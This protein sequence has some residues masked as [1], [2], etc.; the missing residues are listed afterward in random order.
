MRARTL[1]TFFGCVYNC[2]YCVCYDK[3]EGCKLNEYS[4]TRQE[5]LI[6]YLRRRPRLIH[7]QVF[8]NPETWDKIRQELYPH[9]LPVDELVALNKL[10]TCRPSCADCPCYCG[11][12]CEKKEI[13]VSE[14][15]T[16][17]Q[18]FKS[19]QKVLEKR[20]TEAK[21]SWELLR[22]YFGVTLK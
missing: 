8:K 4:E 19:H 7:R 11:L 15:F 20:K 13:L 3:E 1:K 17:I 5:E 9:T 6:E 12:N 18:W 14:P 21:K 10:F 22:K 2:N 16:L